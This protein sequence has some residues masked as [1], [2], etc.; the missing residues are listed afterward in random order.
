MNITNTRYPPVQGFVPVY[1]ESSVLGEAFMIDRYNAGFCNKSFLIR[2]W[3]RSLF[4][5]QG[6]EG[7]CRQWMYF[8]SSYFSEARKRVQKGEAPCDCVAKNSHHAKVNQKLE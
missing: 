8:L 3:Q 4:D 5:M 1:G 2:I 6:A 7:I